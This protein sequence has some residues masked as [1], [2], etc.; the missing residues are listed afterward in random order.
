MAITIKK[1]CEADLRNLMRAVVERIEMGN[2]GETVSPF[3]HEEMTGLLCC[4]GDA[5]ISNHRAQRSQPG[6]RQ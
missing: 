6:V 5:L 2:R 1:Q 3:T 4:V